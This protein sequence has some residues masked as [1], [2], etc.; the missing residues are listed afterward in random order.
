[1]T[2][3][4]HIQLLEM[5]SKNGIGFTDNISKSFM[6]NNFIKPTANTDVEWNIEAWPSRL[7]IDDLIRR[8]FIKF[9]TDEYQLINISFNNW[10]DK[11]DI[12]V[13]LTSHGLDYIDQHEANETSKRANKALIVNVIITIVLSLL[14]IGIS[15]RGLNVSTDTFNISK[16]ASYSDSINA[17]S[18]NKRLDTLTRLISKLQE[19]LSSPKVQKT[20]P[21]RKAPSH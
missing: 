6:V 11:V 16:N 19:S 2:K 1:M 13:Y 12:T 21:S 4:K 10:Y 20:S 15:Y 7:F 5:L 18:V 17:I 3:P 14:I 9:N 8:S